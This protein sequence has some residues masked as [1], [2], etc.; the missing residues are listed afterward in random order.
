MDTPPAAAADQRVQRVLQVVVDSLSSDLEG[1]RVL[2]LGG[3]EGSFALQFALRGAEVVMAEGREGNVARARFAAEA[4]GLDRL[5]VL[6]HDVTTLDEGEL[7]SFDVVLC[8]GVLYH[9]ESRDALSLVEKTFRMS[10]RLAIVETQVALS[11]RR[12]ERLGGHEYLGTPYPEDAAERGAALVSGTSFWPTKPSLLN[13]LADAGFTT[14]AE[15]LMP[16]VPAVDAF[17]DHTTLLAVK[18]ERQ[19]IVSAGGTPAALRRPERLPPL[20]HPAQG[21]RWRLLERAARL[22]GAGLRG[23]FGGPR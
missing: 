20:A 2:D 6:H 8:L 16:V 13:L 14:V 11:G 9:L 23:V 18:G 4:L 1:K 5:R 19:G 22:R 10:R 3:G 7:G 17:R 12:R 21:L 15:V